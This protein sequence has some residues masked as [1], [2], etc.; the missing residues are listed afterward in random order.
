MCICIGRDTPFTAPP[1]GAV[2]DSRTEILPV[3][4][5]V[6]AGEHLPHSSATAGGNPAQLYRSSRTI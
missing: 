2:R 6:P 4:L 3:S 5:L 1:A